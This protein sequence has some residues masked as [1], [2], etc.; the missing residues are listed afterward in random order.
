MRRLFCDDEA[1][2]FLLPT[3]VV[4]CVFG[5]LGL[6]LREPETLTELTYLDGAGLASNFFS[7]AWLAWSDP[8]VLKGFDGRPYSP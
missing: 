4:V 8:L 1:L 2:A 7:S 6:L 3:P 5:T